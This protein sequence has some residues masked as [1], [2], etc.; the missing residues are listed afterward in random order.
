METIEKSKEKKGKVKKI[1]GSK[2]VSD[3]SKIYG[4]LKGK[5]FYD[6]AIFNLG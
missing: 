2:K 4:W 1:Y 5:I 6:E 3:L